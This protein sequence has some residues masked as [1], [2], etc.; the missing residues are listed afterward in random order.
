MTCWAVFLTSCRSQVHDKN[1]GT[2]HLYYGWK[3]KKIGASNLDG[4][5]I[6]AGIIGSMISWTSMHIRIHINMEIDRKLYILRD[7]FP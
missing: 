1:G 2:K 3:E 7:S 5:L 4:P 6:S